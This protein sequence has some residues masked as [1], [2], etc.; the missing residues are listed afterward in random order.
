MS[1]ER[2]RKKEE[3]HYFING[4]SASG[5]AIPMM[6]ARRKP[7]HVLSTENHM[8]SAAANSM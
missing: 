8:N 7:N 2:G 1:G 6:L 4:I 3:N 5:Q